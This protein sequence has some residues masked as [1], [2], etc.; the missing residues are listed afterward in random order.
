MQTKFRVI[1]FVLAAMMILG[2]MAGCSAVNN[3]PEIGRVGNIPITYETYANALQSVRQYYDYGAIQ[4]ENSDNP[5]PELREEAFEQVVDSLIPVAIAYVRGVTLNAEEEASLAEKTE[6]EIKNG[7]DESCAELGSDASEDVKM[8]Y[9]KK[10]LK[11]NGYTMDSYREKVNE[12]VRRQMLA[13]KMKT[14]AEA[15]A[16]ASEEIMKHWYTEEIKYEKQAYE[17]DI[18]AYYNALQYYEYLTGVPPLY[19][20][21][22]YTLIKQ[23]LIMNPAEGEEK[24]VEAIAAEVQKKIDEGVDFDELIAEY[25]EDP[26]MQSNPDG[27]LYCEAINGEYLHEFS[28]AAGAL[29][30][31]EISGPVK[32][33]EGI[34][35]LKCMGE[36]PES[37][38]PYE[39]IE[40][41]LRAYTLQTAKDELYKEALENW[42]NEVEIVKDDKRIEAI[43]MA[44]ASVR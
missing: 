28:E 19:T 17:N 21:K 41:P 24:D 34:H 26:G 8:N 31:G 38:L 5:M 18:A 39:V 43:D 13:D 11:Q 44:Q 9:F 22:G 37:T 30:E 42:R 6:E 36:L 7:I 1:A 10:L 4:V 33:S 25:N 16:V 14:E 35:F 29:K 2:T 15:A 32:T 12:G 23:V 20:P 27:Y 3:N 40:E